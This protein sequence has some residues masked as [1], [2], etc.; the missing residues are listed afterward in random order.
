MG[1]YPQHQT[2][3]GKIAESH[4][5]I[6]SS[7]VI[8][9]ETVEKC[10]K[11]MVSKIEMETVDM[12]NFFNHAH[13]IQ[14]TMGEEF[15]DN[16]CRIHLTKTDLPNIYVADASTHK[17]SALKQMNSNSIHLDSHYTTQLRFLGSEI[18]RQLQKTY[19]F[20]TSP[21][22]QKI[23]SGNTQITTRIDRGRFIKNI[24]TYPSC[25][26]AL[27]HLSHTETH[28]ADVSSSYQY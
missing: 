2:K 9:N 3:I 6:G 10:Q 15:Y 12:K 17:K 25:F 13:M 24:G 18:T 28:Q 26:S 22:C 8:W 4:G 7:T 5:Y 16:E 14:I 20:T 11:S 23:I 27:K 19:S 21:L 1:V